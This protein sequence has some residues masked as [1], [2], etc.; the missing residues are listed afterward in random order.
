[1]S[2]LQELRDKYG[3]GDPETFTIKKVGVRVPIARWEADL[4]RVDESMT[5]QSSARLRREVDAAMERRIRQSLSNQATIS[6]EEGYRTLG[7]QVANFDSRLGGRVRY[8]APDSP[9]PTYTDRIDSTASSL[10]TD[11]AN[12]SSAV[13]NLSAEMHRTAASTIPVVDAI[14]DSMNRIARR[15]R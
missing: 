1:M 3:T 15:N 11:M 13:S 7:E 8:A 10:T 14:V 12:L 5:E 2:R 6:Q 9:A 4:L